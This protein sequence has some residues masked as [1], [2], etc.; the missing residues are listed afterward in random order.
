MHRNVVDRNRDRNME[1]FILCHLK[2]R[3]ETA[4][5]LKFTGTCCMNI[6]KIRKYYIIQLFLHIV[7]NV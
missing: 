4:T 5:I 6:R 7:S 2:V 1:K 3:Q